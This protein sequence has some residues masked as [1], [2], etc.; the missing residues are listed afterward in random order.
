MS[1]DEIRTFEINERTGKMIDEL[2]EVYGTPTRAATLNRVVALAL[3]LAKYCDKDGV[4]HFIDRD[5][6]PLE[7]AT[8]FDE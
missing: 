5:G 3:I 4:I 2:S 1:A 6:Q 8:R 7:V